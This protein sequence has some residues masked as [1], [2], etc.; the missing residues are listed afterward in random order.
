MASQ[1]LSEVYCSTVE[2]DDSVFWDLYRV[3]VSHNI[4]IAYSVKFLYI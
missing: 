1:A 4:Q 2:S 3:S